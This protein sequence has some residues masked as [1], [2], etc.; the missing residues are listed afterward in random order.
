MSEI[1]LLQINTLAYISYFVIRLTLNPYYDFRTF[2]CVRCERTCYG[3]RV[4]HSFCQTKEETNIYENEN[5]QQEVC[6]CVVPAENIG[7][8]S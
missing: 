4:L 2:M 8:T 5:E 7:L 6:S 3:V 1:Y